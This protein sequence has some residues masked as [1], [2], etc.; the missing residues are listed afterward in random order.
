MD[1]LPIFRRILSAKQ[2]VGLNKNRYTDL[3]KLASL[4]GAKENLEKAKEIIQNAITLV[5]DNRKVLPLKLTGKMP[6]PLKSTPSHPGTTAARNTFLCC[7]HTS[8]ARLL[9]TRA[10]PDQGNRE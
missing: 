7:A 4:L 9:Q 1:A 8:A 3:E 2:K 10:C 6:V 5:R